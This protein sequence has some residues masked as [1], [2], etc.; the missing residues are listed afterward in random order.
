[1]TFWRRFYRAMDEEGG[2]ALFFGM[3]LWAAWGHLRWQMLTA[4]FLGLLYLFFLR[5]FSR[6]SEPAED[7]LHKNPAALASVHRGLSQ[8]ATNQFVPEPDT[9]DDPKCADA[10]WVFENGIAVCENCRKPVDEIFADARS[11]HATPSAPT[12]EGDERG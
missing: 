3:S 10:S 4:W 1:M 12:S 11:R 8:A 9:D 5:G 7:W 6:T 2:P